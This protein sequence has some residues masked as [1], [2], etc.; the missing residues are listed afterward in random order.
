LNKIFR[1]KVLS[2]R[3]QFAV[4][5]SYFYYVPV[6]RVLCGFLLERVRGHA[7]VWRYAMPLYERMDILNLNFGERLP[8]PEGSMWGFGTGADA[9]VEFVR[10]IEPYERETLTWHDP[11]VL[12]RRYEHSP[13]MGNPWVR[14]SIAWTYI[15]VGRLAE[16]RAHL[17]ALLSADGVDRYPHFIDDIRLMLNSMDSGLD[18][19]RRL[20]VAW[21]QQTK[22][23]LNIGESPA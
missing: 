19:A 17:Q 22:R 13:A 1:A 5:G 23:Q 6:G 3:P 8:E 2:L 16:A 4:T 15:L 18:E 14:R 7:Y 9:A 20:L 12:L 21:E 10:R 11:D